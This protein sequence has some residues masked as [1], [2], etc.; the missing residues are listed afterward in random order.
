MGILAHYYQLDKEQTEKILNKICSSRKAFYEVISN[1]EGI[2]RSLDIDK[3]WQ[4]LVEVFKDLQIDEKESNIGEITFY[5]KELNKPYEPDGLLNYSGYETV[6]KINQ[7]LQ[8]IPIGTKED[9]I[10]TFNSTQYTR[11]GEI[12][13]S[14][15]Y[16][17][18]FLHLEN[19]KEFYLKCEKEEFGVVVSIG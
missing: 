19:L 3:S 10:K 2:Q 14:E 6:K 8:L 17:Y 12:D 9:F 5:G 16:D 4:Y 7:Y 13:Y 18:L 15:Y 11:F 1:R